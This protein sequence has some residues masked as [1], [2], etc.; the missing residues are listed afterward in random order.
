MRRLVYLAITSLDGFI[1]DDQGAFDWAMPDVE[2]HEFVNDIE[3]RLGTHL[4]GRRM[5]E[6][7]AVWQTIGDQPDLSA[8]EVAFADDWRSVDKIV[9]SRTLE[10]VTTPRT[11]LEREFE[12]D[13]VRLLKRTADR[14]IGIGGPALAAHAFRAGLVDEIHLFAFPIVVGG[15]KPGLPRDVSVD[16][17]LVDQ[18]RFGNGVVYTH[19]RAR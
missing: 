18:Q 8:A 9:Y 11:T 16:L 6:T 5:Y 19:H 3:R 4:Y 17:Q 15:G 7:M 10:A 12:A 14:D 13:R 2:V 1:E